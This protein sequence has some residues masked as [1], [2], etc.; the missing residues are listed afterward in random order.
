MDSVYI[1]TYGLDDSERQGDYCV[2]HAF[3]NQDGAVAAIMQMQDQAGGREC[4]K[5]EKPHPNDSHVICEWTDGNIRYYL[6]RLR[7]L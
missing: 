5:K 4:F 6:E 1:A 3:T 7:I 2:A